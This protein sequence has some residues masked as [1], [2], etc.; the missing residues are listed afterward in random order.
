[1]VAL[2]RFICTEV[3]AFSNHFTINGAK[4]I[5]RYREVPSIEVPLSRII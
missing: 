5:V 2:K 4:Q 3:P 1:M